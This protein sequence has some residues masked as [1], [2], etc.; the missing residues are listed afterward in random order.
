MILVGFL[1]IFGAYKNTRVFSFPLCLT[2]NE[3]PLDSVRAYVEISNCLSQ[4]SSN[5]KEKRIYC[6]N[7]CDRT[8]VFNDFDVHH[9]NF[10][11]FIFKIQV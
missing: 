1:N 11:L 5:L 8:F 2:N 4:E 10:F 9:L 3:C 7:Y 6:F